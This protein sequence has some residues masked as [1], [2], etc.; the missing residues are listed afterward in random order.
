MRLEYYR[1]IGRNHWVLDD[2]KSRYFGGLSMTRD[3]TNNMLRGLIL[4]TVYTGLCPRP[5]NFLRN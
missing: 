1:V 5:S 2:I 4:N 3:D